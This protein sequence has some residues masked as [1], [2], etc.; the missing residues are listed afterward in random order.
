MSLLDEAVQKDHVPARLRKEH[1]CDTPTNEVAS[2]LEQ[3]R[4]ASQRCT[5]RRAARPA[6]FDSHKV[7][8]NHFAVLTRELGQAFANSLPAT[9]QPKEPSKDY[10]LGPWHPSDEPQLVHW[11]L[12]PL[13]INDHGKR[14]ERRR[15]KNSQKENHLDS[16]PSRPHGSSTRVTPAPGVLRPIP[17]VE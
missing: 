9:C 10:L 8:T 14:S 1:P 11:R 17:P 6:E 12:P 15:K 13:T 5:E 3:A 4:R 7:V 2:H 16:G